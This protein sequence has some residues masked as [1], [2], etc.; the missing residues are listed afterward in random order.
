MD[1]YVQ[2]KQTD[3]AYFLEH[4]DVTEAEVI[5]FIVVNLER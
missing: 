5:I 4:Y 2:N 3:L 1:R